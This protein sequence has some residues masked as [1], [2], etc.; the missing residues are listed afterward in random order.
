MGNIVECLRQIVRCRKS[1]SV[2]SKEH[3]EK[4]KKVSNAG[5]DQWLRDVHLLRA[6]AFLCTAE[7]FEIGTP[8]GKKFYYPMHKERT[9]TNVDKMISAEQNLDKFWQKLDERLVPDGI[10]QSYGIRI[11]LK[12]APAPKR[13]VA[14]VEPLRPESHTT[15]KS[16]YTKPIMFQ[17][18][19][20]SK[21]KFVAPEPK[22]EKEKTRGVEAPS[23]EAQPRE[24][25]EVIIPEDP[26]IEVDFDALR[27]F[28]TLFHEFG[29]RHPM[30][31][32]AWEGFKKAMM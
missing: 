17:K 23:E 4:L 14:W 29:Q 28:K 22:K 3:L 24:E 21:E 1:S 18:H 2:E 9:K 12:N 26:K 8:K 32:V 30:R 15:G 31:E 10:L 19:G 11:L 7:L 16:E 25:E 27:I 13:T 5:V 20:E 6:F